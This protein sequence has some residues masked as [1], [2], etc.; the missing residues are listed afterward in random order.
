L[1][2]FKGQD[3][4]GLK[5]YHPLYSQLKSEVYPGEHVTSE[6]GTGLVHIASGFGEDD[7]H[8]VKKVGLP[9]F[10]PID[11]QG[12]FSSEIKDLDSQLVGVFYDDANKII[13][14]RLSDN[15]HLLKLKFLTH[16]YPHD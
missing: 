4:V 16:S 7:Y 13:T 1:K 6:A 8:L 2:T 9:I 11:D 10:A 14:N 5:Y 12:K 15:H 3:L